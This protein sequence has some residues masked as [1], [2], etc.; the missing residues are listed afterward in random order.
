MA[1][2]RGRLHFHIRHSN[3]ANARLRFQDTNEL[4][5]GEDCLHILLDSGECLSPNA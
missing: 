5:T 2:A 4:H 3:G 1:T